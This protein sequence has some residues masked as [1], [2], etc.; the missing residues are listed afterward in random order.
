MTVLLYALLALFG[1][2]ALFG[3]YD[4]YKQRRGRSEN[5]PSEP[6]TQPSQRA[7]CGLTDVCT[8]N[9][10]LAAPQE[11]AEYYDDEEL[12]VFKGIRSDQYTSEQTAAFAEV[13]DT[14]LKTD[15]HGWLRSLHKRGIQLPAA[16]K[17][18]ALAIVREVGPAHAR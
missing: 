7:A 9:C 5:A 10:A 16:L 17:P 6:K 3:L 11:P 18:K 1:F 14:M 4:Y 12:D 15:V 8:M 2:A 13:L